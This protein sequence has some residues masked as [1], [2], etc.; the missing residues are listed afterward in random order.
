MH[1]FDEKTSSSGDLSGVDSPDDVNVTNV[2]ITR[3]I[4]VLTVG[5][6]VNYPNAFVSGVQD[7][8][9]DYGHAFF[10]I[11]Q[12]DKVTVFFSFG[13]NGMAP[14][15]KITNEYTGP[16]PGTTSY[17]IGETIRLFR[18]K[19]TEE[20]AV[21]VKS[22]AKCFTEKVNA[23]KE[24]YHAFMNDTCA[25]TARDI[26]SAGGV[27]TPSGSGPVKG[28]G[29]NALTSNAS[30][31]NPYK[32]YSDFTKEY[33]TKGIVCYG[34]GGRRNVTSDLIHLKND[35]ILSPGDDDVL[36][37]TQQV[38]IHGEVTKK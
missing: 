27:A 10:Y 35:W 25:E 30:F 2:Q 20:M 12:N 18:L 23:G 36:L 28:I 26:L 29:I 14:P 6:E 1:K 11:T 9:V 5:F 4:Y 3:K 37:S 8:S 15:G 21:N 24:H 17:A 38:I 34:P 7:L 13:P 19:I 16:R 22:E 33:S 31:V 32:W